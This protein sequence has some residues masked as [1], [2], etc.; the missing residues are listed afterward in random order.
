MKQVYDN[1]GKWKFA[2]MHLAK[3]DTATEVVNIV[4]LF[5]A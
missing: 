1:A 4:V 5:V 3:Y 2:G